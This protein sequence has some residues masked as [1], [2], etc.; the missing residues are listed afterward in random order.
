MIREAFTPTEMRAEMHR[1]RHENTVVH[2]VMTQSDRAGYS[3]EDRYTIIAYY[4]LLE[5]E[6][7]K[8]QLMDFVLTHVPP[9]IITK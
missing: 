2:R 1:L 9:V 7:A 6:R 3:A 8:E 4:A 5:A